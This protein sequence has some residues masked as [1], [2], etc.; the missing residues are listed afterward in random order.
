MKRLLTALV[1]IAAAIGAGAAEPRAAPGEEPAGVS[2][3]A[4]DAT[5]FKDPYDPGRTARV[6]IQ[7]AAVQAPL[8]AFAAGS[9]TWGLAG[10]A[11]W[12]RLDFQDYPGLGAEDLRGA[13]LGLFADQPAADR[14]G[15]SAAVMPG[16]F[17][18]ARLMAQ[19][20]V[21][22]RLSPAWRLELGAA[23]DDAFGEPRLFP[24]G[25]AV[26]EAPGGFALRL[27]FPASSAHWAPTENLGLFALVAPAGNRWVTRDGGDEWIF[28]LEGWRAGLGAEGRL[29]RNLWVRIAG[30]REFA[31][32]YEAERDGRTELDEDVAEAWFASVALVVQ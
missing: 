5:A 25:G 26:W 21:R 8:A 18:E 7:E 28:V 24:V 29:W 6:R 2:Y 13:A 4:T 14:W 15:W 9:A 30:G 20:L 32:R 10:W 22:R 11:G 23:W 1:P 19:G 16:Y 12:T 17:G 31:R 3:L 27:R